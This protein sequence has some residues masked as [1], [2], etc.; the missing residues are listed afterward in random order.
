MPKTSAGLLVYRRK[1]EFPEVLLVH[2]GGP[3]WRKRDDGAW[4][5]PK[6]E[7]GAGEDAQAAAFR[8][9]AEELGVTPPSASPHPLGE[10]VQAGGKHVVAFAVEGD[11]DVRTIQSNSFE[12]EWPPGSGRRESFPEVDRADWFNLN[13]A[14]QKIIPGQQPL[15]ERLEAILTG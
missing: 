8:E 5:I 13:A 10:V 14:K 12:M 3:F 1:A 7:Y 9:F 4:S 11:F 6:G 15:L 2:P